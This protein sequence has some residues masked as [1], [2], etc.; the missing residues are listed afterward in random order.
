LSFRRQ[1]QSDDGALKHSG[2][3]LLLIEDSRVFST[4]V[5][6][7]VEAYLGLTVTHCASLVGLHAA[8]AGGAYDIAVLDLNLPDAPNCQALD[9]V[10]SHGIPAIVFTGSFND[11]TRDAVMARGVVD[12][13]IKN[14]R[15]SVPAVIDAV[16]RVLSNVGTGVLIADTDPER[17]GALAM[18]LRQQQFRVVEVD[19][20]QAV[21]NATL[22][23]GIDLV[24]SEYAVPGLS[25]QALLTGLRTLEGETLV[26]VIAIGPDDARGHAARFIRAGG[27]DF[28][29][30]PFVGDE[31][32]SRLSR[33]IALHRRIAMLQRLASRDFL[34]DLYNRRFFFQEGPRMVDQCFRR[35]SGCSIAIL[36]IDHFK[37]LNDTFGHEVGDLVLKAVARTLKTF[38]G[39]DH[40]LARLGGEE[41]GVLFDGLDVVAANDYCEQLRQTIARTQVVTDDEDLSITVSIGLAPIEHPE[42]FDNYLNAAD[43]FLY[44]A[45]HAG[46]NRIVSELTMIRSM[47]S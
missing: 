28:V 6:H 4:L 3:H 34:T 29:Q 45:K 2:R 11:S 24:V 47:A 21:L 27:A 42:M 32:S 9:L 44:M 38:I 16:D 18:F 15:D 46:R 20:E 22:S 1:Q 39:N 43:Q 41:F 5:R 14:D 25:A 19:G 40:L 26:P 37:R 23:G 36:D 31:F 10:L 13:I 7:D 35:T 30:R 12:C 17:R 8:I 33:L